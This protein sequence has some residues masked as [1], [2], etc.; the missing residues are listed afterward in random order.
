M[1]VI[2]IYNRNLDSIELLLFLH[3]LFIID[4]IEKDPS[5]YFWLVI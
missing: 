3:N 2:D 1:S 5:K 4:D